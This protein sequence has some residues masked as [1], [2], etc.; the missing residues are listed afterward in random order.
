MTRPPGAVASGCA[1]A[2][3]LATLDADGQARAWVAG[4]G[5]VIAALGAAGRPDV[6]GLVEVP[7]VLGDGVPLF[8]P[9]VP[10]RGLRPIAA[11]PKPS[12]AMRLL[13]GR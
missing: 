9:G 6:L 5:K 8:P 2:A 11:E 10:G 13:Y 3:A 1:V 12:G 7:I 4:G